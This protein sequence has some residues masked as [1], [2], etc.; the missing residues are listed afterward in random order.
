MELKLYEDSLRRERKDYNNRFELK[1]SDFL[2][3]VQKAIIQVRFM[4]G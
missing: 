1:T 3:E 2:P 4:W